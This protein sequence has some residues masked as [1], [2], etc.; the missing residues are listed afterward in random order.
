M[1]A[2]R[3]ILIYS[4]RPFN[5]PVGAGRI[6]P[7]EGRKGTNIANSSLCTLKKPLRQQTRAFLVANMVYISG[8][9]VVQSEGILS[10]GFFEKV[11]W[12]VPN[13][14]SFFFSVSFRSL[15]QRSKVGRR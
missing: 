13:A 8:G 1:Y 9:Q 6:E 14:I 7:K 3:V 4:T 11:L 12:F 15:L 10:L 2:L 5:S